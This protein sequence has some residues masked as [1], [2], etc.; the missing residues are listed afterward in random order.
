MNQDLI[1]HG[2]KT[3]NLKDVTVTIP[4]NKFVVFTGVS[5]SGKSS[6]V[7]DT[8]YT[9]AQRQLIETFSAFARK[10]MPKLSRP[11]V[12]EIEHLATAIMIDQKRL[13]KSSRSTVGTVNDILSYM[14]MLFSRCGEPEHLPQA[15]FSFNLPDGMCPECLGKGQ[16]HRVIVERFV[17][18]SKSLNEGAILHP[19]YKVGSWMWKELIGSKLFD[20]DKSL[21]DWPQSELDILLYAE[22]FPLKEVSSDNFKKTFEGLIRKV[23]RNRNLKDEEDS[24]NNKQSIEQ[25]FEDGVCPACHGA[26]LNERS[27][28]IRV[29]GKT[30]VELSS[31]E[32]DE[33]DQFLANIDDPL[34]TK[35]VAKIRRILGHLIDIGVS[36]LSLDRPVATLSGGESQRVKMAKQLDCDLTGLLYILDEP[37]TGLH[38]RDDKQLI[39]LLYG[40]RDRGNSVYVVEHNPDIIEAADWV[41]DIGPKAGKFGGTVVFNGPTAELKNTDT[42][43]AK[44][45]TTFQNPPQRTYQRRSASDYFFIENAT[46]HNLKNVSV[47]IPKGIFTCVTGVA[48]SGKSSLIHDVFLKEHPEAVVVDQSAPTKSSRAIP[49]TYIGAFDLMRK[50]L[51]KRT[52]EDAS[53]FSFNSKGGCPTCKG[54]GSVAVT[55]GFMDDVRMTCETCG[56][57]RY[58]EEVRAIICD[59]KNITDILAMNPS[60][61]FDFFESKEI[62]KKLQAL[63]E[64]GLGYMA[65]GQSFSTLSGGECQRIKIA[66]ELYKKGNIY[67]LDEPTTGLHMADVHNFMDIVDNL[68]NQGNTVIIIEHNVDVMSRAD[69]IIDMGPEGG[70]RGGEVLFTGTPEDLIH[71]EQS[72]TGKFLK[73]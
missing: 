24:E 36:Y 31:M 14:R 29:A 25:F 43:T 37:S 4:K 53:L 56:G 68:V 52:G 34:A 73:L 65:I 44:Y 69:W 60:E 46:V 61:A 2:A 39:E 27:R 71:C 58:R 35:I 50:E 54:A 38:P 11:P 15:M 19:Y 16:V 41:I 64:V 48:G 12:D 8:I 9:E 30:I 13:G 17:D 21:Q 32:L 23:E 66:A 26:R 49:V 18:Y 51:A 62:R 72:Y 28:N 42:A 3:N 45:L 22:E 40:L 33:L 10:R 67:I 57:S 6:L 59:G 63:I 47:K 5:G 20:A 55:M 70:N 7:F 1:I